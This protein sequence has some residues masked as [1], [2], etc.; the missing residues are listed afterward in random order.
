MATLANP[1]GDSSHRHCGRR[2]P[3]ED[4]FEAI[5]SCP[6]LPEPGQMRPAAERCLECKVLSSRCQPFNFSDEDTASGNTGG[7]RTKRRKSRSNQ[8][9]VHEVQDTGIPRQKLSRERGFSG[10]VGTGDNDAPRLSAS[11]GHPRRLTV[12]E[13]SEGRRFPLALYLCGRERLIG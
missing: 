10:P 12:S 8:V 9:S 2:Q 4:H 6:P 1:S 5:A 11:L 3:E 7:L 13:S